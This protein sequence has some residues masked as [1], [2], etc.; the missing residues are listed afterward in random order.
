[1]TLN[2]FSAD[3]QFPSDPTSCV[4]SYTSSGTHAHSSSRLREDVCIDAN[5][6]KQHNTSEPSN[7]LLPDLPPEVT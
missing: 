6:D 5:R 3:E 2:I 7:D 4:G 1:M